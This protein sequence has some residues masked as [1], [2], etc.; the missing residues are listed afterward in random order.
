MAVCLVREIEKDPFFLTQSADEIQIGFPI[1]HAVFPRFV[2]VEEAEIHGVASE[3]VFQKNALDNLDHGLVLKDPVI[4]LF[5]KKPQPRHQ[6]TLVVRPGSSAVTLDHMAY[7]AVNIP[8]GAAFVGYGQACFRIQ[9]PGKI[10]V[11]GFAHQLD[12]EF[13]GLANFFLTGKSIYSE[14]ALGGR[15]GEPTAIC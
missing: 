8:R 9:E 7:E 14:I 12:A 15:Y 6:P 2:P 11:G 13:I 1:L 5:L 4:P 10:L 3:S